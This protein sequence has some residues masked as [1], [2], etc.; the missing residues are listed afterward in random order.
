MYGG[1][2]ESSTDSVVTV[3]FPEPGEYSVEL[4]VNGGINGNDTLIRF[5]TVEDGNNGKR[6]NF[7]FTF[8]NGILPNDINVTG[9]PADEIG[10][11]S[12]DGPGAE[13][14]KGCIFL[15]NI[16]SELTSG[17]KDYFETP[18]FD[19]SNVEK[20]RFSYYYAYRCV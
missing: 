11:I 19:L 3:R 9:T 5:V 13:N 16:S 8:A 1:I 12:L 17:H 20:P 15:N 14:T 18:Y 7:E 4:I 6:P 2:P 10:W